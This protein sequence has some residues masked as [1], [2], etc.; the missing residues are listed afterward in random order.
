MLYK[1]SLSVLKLFNAHLLQC[2]G[3]SPSVPMSTKATFISAL[4]VAWLLV[5]L[6]PA[7]ICACAVNPWVNNK[8][9]QA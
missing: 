6:C 2:E 7:P 3:G 9:G 1:S 5:I 8:S 4:N